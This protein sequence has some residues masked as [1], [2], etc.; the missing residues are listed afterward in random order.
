MPFEDALST[1]GWHEDRKEE[2][3]EEGEHLKTKDSLK[4]HG[5][6]QDKTSWSIGG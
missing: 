4:P 1:G 2:D 5:L 6:L 3:Q